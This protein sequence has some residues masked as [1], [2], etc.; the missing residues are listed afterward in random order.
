MIR[1]KILH[2]V[3]VSETITKKD[4]FAM[5]GID[6]DDLEKFEAMLSESADLKRLVRSPVFAA[7]AQLKALSAVLSIHFLC[8]FL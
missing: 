7:D 3:K 1:K 4:N 2:R 6:I 5:N 8:R